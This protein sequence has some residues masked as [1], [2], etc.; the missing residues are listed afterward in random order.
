MIKK[1]VPHGNALALIIDRPIL[2]LLR[3]EAHTP[4]EIET[5]D[6]K[7]LTIRPVR[8]SVALKA[9]MKEIN[10]KYRKTLK[11]LDK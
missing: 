4:L 7:S 5:V 2:E 6:G 10:R 1:L 3:I 11:N 8:N 9:A